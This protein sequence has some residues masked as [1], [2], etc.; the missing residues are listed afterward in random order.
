MDRKQMVVVGE[1]CFEA[2]G[3][4]KKGFVL[5]LFSILSHVFS[6]SSLFNFFLKKG[7]PRGTP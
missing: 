2:E 7:M 5:S 6:H 1:F 4:S 3:R